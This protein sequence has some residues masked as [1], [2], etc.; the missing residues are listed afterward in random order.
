MGFDSSNAPTK[1]SNVTDASS[2]V[3]DHHRVLARTDD[4]GG[5]GDLPA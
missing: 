4:E 1:P 2:N 5:D 3:T